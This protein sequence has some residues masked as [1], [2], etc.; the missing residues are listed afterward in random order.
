MIIDRINGVSASENPIAMTP[1]LNTVQFAALGRSL[2]ISGHTLPLLQSGYFLNQGMLRSQDSKSHPVDGIGTGSIDRE[3]MAGPGDTHL[4]FDPLAAA[5]PV[6]LHSQDVLR[7]VQR[8]QVGQQFISVGS[9]AEIPLLHI[10]L[11]NPTM[12]APTYAPSL[13]LFVRQDSFALRA[14]PLPSRGSISQATLIQ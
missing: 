8:F 11:I 2:A 13:N 1:P 12:A 7:P 9:N 10:P 3:V 14:P 5:N 6:A 4:E